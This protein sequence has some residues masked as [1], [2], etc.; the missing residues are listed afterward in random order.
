MRL[1]PEDTAPPARLLPARV[2]ELEAE[3]AAL[4]GQLAALEAAP[5]HEAQSAQGRLRAE[6]SHDLR[7]PLAALALYASMLKGHVAPAGAPLLAH[8]KTCLATLND[9]L[10]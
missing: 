10:E 9:L 1:T 4:R 5:A 3:N 6:F 8:M 2:I 7:Q